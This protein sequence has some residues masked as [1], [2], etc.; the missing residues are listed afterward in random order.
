MTC[1]YIL[2]RYWTYHYFFVPGFFSFWRPN[3]PLNVPRFPVCCGSIQDFPLPNWAER[4]WLM[5][6][7]VSACYRI[8]LN[9]TAIFAHDMFVHTLQMIVNILLFLR[10]R[11]FFI[12]T[13]KSSSGRT[14]QTLLLMS[15]CTRFFS[16]WHFLSY[17]ANLAWIFVELSFGACLQHAA[18]LRVMSTEN[19]FTCLIIFWN[20]IL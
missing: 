11:I 16:C 9:L 5:S 17:F 19:I 15:G 20:S 14:Y 6:E 12:L 4:D 1:S 13:A 8:F 3:L 2:F 10:S 18:V 7:K